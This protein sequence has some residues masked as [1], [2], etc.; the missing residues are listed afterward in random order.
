M[1]KKQNK[2]AKNKK[3]QNKNTK[4]KKKTN[5]NT[6]QKTNPK[7]SKTASLTEASKEPSKNEILFFKIGVSVIAIGLVVVAI[8]MIVSNFMNKE[9]INPYIDYNHFKTEELAAMTKYID[10]TTYGDLDYFTGK[11]EYEDIRVILNQ[12]DI[13]YFYFY[14][15]NQI[16]EEIKT[17]IDKLEGVENLPLIFINLDAIDNLNLFEDENLTHL[18]LDAEL[19]DMLLIYD[20]Q[21]D[22]IDEFFELQTNVS[23]IIATL[24]GNL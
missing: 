17:E 24:E 7:K 23:D 11:T 12:N 4:N 9:E 21:P 18:N 1:A 13:F 3:K 14:H 8:V 15:S 2:N 6:T 5:H 10:E 20:M 22:S 19:D 16:N